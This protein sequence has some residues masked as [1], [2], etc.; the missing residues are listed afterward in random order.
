MRYLLVAVLPCILIT[1]SAARR[2]PLRRT[3]PFPLPA[4]GGRHNGAILAATFFPGTN[5][6]VLTETPD[7]LR[8]GERFTLSSAAC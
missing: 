3:G 5:G 1:V 7:V 4:S 6:V 2:H 8:P